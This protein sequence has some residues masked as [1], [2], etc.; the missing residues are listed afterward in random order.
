MLLKKHN[1][2]SFLITNFL[3]KVELSE[4]VEKDTC[5]TF[6]ASCIPIARF[7]VCLLVFY[8]KQ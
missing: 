7:L 3:Q 2:M 8:C 6:Y 4:I 1:G 5:I